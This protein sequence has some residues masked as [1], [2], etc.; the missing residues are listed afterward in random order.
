MA[1]VD[2]APE[3]ASDLG[4]RMTDDQTDF[5][6]RPLFLGIVGRVH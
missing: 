4:G 6:I 1:S 5:G 2:Y 3:S